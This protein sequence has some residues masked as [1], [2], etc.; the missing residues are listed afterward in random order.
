MR[1]LYAITATLLGLV[2]LGLGIGQ[3]TT[4][5]EETYT[6]PTEG[7]QDAPFTV[8]T[9]DLINSDAER[10]EFTIEAE[11]EY[12]LAMGRTHDIEAWIGD[13][14]YNRVAG[15]EE[16][17]SSDDTGRIVA[18]YVDGESE[19]PNPADSD[20]WVDSETTEGDLLYRWNTP[21]ESGD[22]AL[23]IFRDGEEPAPTAITMTETQYFSHAGGIAMV[24]GGGIVL[25]IGLGLFYWAVG[26]PRRRRTA[27]ATGTS[28]AATEP[29]SAASVTT[30]SATGDPH[31]PT[32]NELT[33]S[34]DT[35]NEDT[36]QIGAP[37]WGP[38]AVADQAPLGDEE[39]G[40]DEVGADEDDD[41]H[42]P[43]DD[44]HGDDEHD[45]E[46]HDE[47]DKD[48]MNP[49]DA[50]QPQS[51]PDSEGLSGWAKGLRERMQGGRSPFAAGLA[52][53]L[54]LGA[55]LGLATPAHADE[56]PAEEDQPDAEEVEDEQSGEEPEV[57]EE[58]PSEGY[59]VLLS[60]QL[61]RIVE[62]LAEVVAE[63]D[64]ELDA[65][66]LTDR[67]AGDALEARELAY[68][69]HEA[70]DVSLPAPVGTE[71]LSAAV[72]GDAEF[73]R[74]AF[75]IVEHPDTDVPQILVLEQAEPRENY[76]L[77]HTSMMAPGTEFPS[78]SPEQGG[79]SAPEI[80]SE[81][82][83]LPPSR[84][85][86]GV[87]R[88]FVDSGFAFGEEIAESLYIEALHE[89]Y[90]E[91]TD[92]TDDAEVNFPHPEVNYESIAALELPDGSTVAAGSFESVM[93]LAPISDGDTIFLEHDLVVELAGTDWTTFPAQIT[94]MEQV[95]V[96]IPPEGSDEQIVLL[97][98]DN[99]ISD[100]S[101]DAP[102]WF[103]GY[104]DD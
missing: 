44:E 94:S 54:A 79:V 62:D 32:G 78:F 72:T 1:I 96:Q 19:A 12:T 5:A 2:L 40:A 63:G 6:V 49:T 87:S 95:V 36:V 70:A 43:G 58:I 50:A 24:V 7:A 18:E 64:E 97:G 17:E 37:A 67:V 28:A 74:Q 77:V 69:N 13:A 31:E 83:D 98:V 29:S 42:N 99:L 57:A 86:R 30:G 39:S 26:A 3:L 14:A 45:S 76:K 81:D 11:G 100:A 93:E 89:Y 92:A 48:P 104:D 61:D 47:N 16:G 55:G 10:E 33:G 51:Q 4:E 52:M 9:E 8:I 46:D 22:W 53:V 91:L 21:D 41:E 71:V 80:D 103:D 35:G 27:A 25:L 75:V 56:E 101:I 84:A 68:R 66:L 59:S 60:S 102:D 23:M 90:E 20:L 65:E 88:Y 85:I 34:Q 73:P 82:T 38:P 15:F